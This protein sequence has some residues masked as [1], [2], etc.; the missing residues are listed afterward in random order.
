MTNSSDITSCVGVMSSNARVV[1]EFLPPSAPAPEPIR[2]VSFW[3]GLACYWC[4]PR[5]RNYLNAGPGHRA[6]AAFVISNAILMAELAITLTLVFDDETSS[7]DGVRSRAAMAM[8]KMMSHMSSVGAAEPYILM[9]ILTLPVTIGILFIGVGLL[10]APTE[11][12]GERIGVLVRWA[13]KRSLWWGTALPWA[14][15][16]GVLFAIMNQDS[17]RLPPGRGLKVILEVFST[18]G[19]P[20]FLLA[21]LYFISLALRGSRGARRVVGATV[22]GPG[23]SHRRP[24]CEDCGYIISGLNGNAACPECGL[25]VARSM[26]GGRR[27]ELRDVMTGFAAWRPKSWIRVWKTLLAQPDAL[28][29]VPILDPA[30]V[31]RAFVHGPVVSVLPG[32]VLLIA[33]IV[34]VELVQ[35]KTPL[36]IAC[37]GLLY[38]MVVAILQVVYAAV[39][40]LYAPIRYGVRDVRASSSVATYAGMLFYI[41]PIVASVMTLAS[42]FPSLRD[43]IAPADVVREIA[44]EQVILVIAVF[45]VLLIY[46]SFTLINGLRVAAFANS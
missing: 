42:F 40:G 6:I 30:V 19:A 32:A 4:S 21:L 18:G 29:R 1:P 12:A 27:S 22:D 25:P 34:R 44:I 11:G 5:A 43:I 41:L 37:F 9:A 15:A 24:Q 10:D 45:V 13:V 8:I 26:P 23:L 33:A 2:R 16:I 7:S 14:G 38:V 31:S 46:S 17:R 39:V 20:L 28:R 36:V 3:K 35:D